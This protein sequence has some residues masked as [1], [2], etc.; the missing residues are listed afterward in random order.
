MPTVQQQAPNLAG[1]YSVC[2]QASLPRVGIDEHY[3]SDVHQPLGGVGAVISSIP[4]FTI[5]IMIISRLF[6]LLLRRPAGCKMDC[7]VL[8]YTIYIHYSKQLGDENSQHVRDLWAWTFL[9]LISSVIMLYLFLS[10]TP[11]QC[12]ISTRCNALM[13]VMHVLQQDAPI[14]ANQGLGFTARQV[15]PTVVAL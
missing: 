10:S 4:T 8:F 13:H 12:K 14:M 11:P 3:R 6:I 15:W 1:A 7:L 2:S 9:V 5:I